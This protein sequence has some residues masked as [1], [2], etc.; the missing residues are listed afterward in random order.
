MDL[1]AAVHETR[2]LDDACL[3]EVARELPGA[4]AQRLAQHLVVRGLLTPYQ[5]DQLLSGQGNEL[6]LGP[7][8]LLDLLG[9]GGMGQVFK[10]LHNP[11]GRTVALKVIRA[12]R[13]SQ[14]PEAVRRFQREARAA[15]QLCHPNVIT[16]FDADSVDNRHYLAMEFVE[17]ID[18]SRL[19][20]Q[21]GPLPIAHACDFIRQ[22][23][24]GLQHA[25]ER[26]LVH[27]D[28]K[29]S[30]LLVSLPGN[31]AEVTDS[32]PTPPTS[33]EAGD[34][35]VIRRPLAAAT[36]LPPLGTLVK[37]VDMGLARRLNVT[38][39]RSVDGSMTEDGLLMGTPDYIAP[40][41]ARDSHRVDIRA[42]LYSLGCTFYYLLTGR[43]PFPEGSTVEK[44]LA[45]QMDEPPAVARLRPDLPV[46]VEM[47]VRKLMS[48]RPEDRYQT[49]AALAAAL[50]TMHPDGERAA[51]A[52][53][54]A[55]RGSAA[56]QPTQLMAA[57]EA[58]RTP[59]SGSAR[60]E[61]ASDRRTG[62]KIAVLKGH[63]GWVTGLA[64][65][66]DHRQLA[67]GGVDGT[68]RLWSLANARTHD[69]ALPRVHRGD[70][71]ALAFSPDGGL[72]ASGPTTLDGLVWL[73]DIHGEM[74]RDLAF[75]QAHQ[76]VTAL[77]FSPDGHT[78]AGGTGPLIRLW[79]IGDDRIKER[80]VLKGHVAPINALAFSADGQVLASAS[81]DGTARLWNPR[82]QF[83]G[84]DPPVVLRHGDQVQSVSFSPDG[85]TVASGGLDQKV[86][87]WDRDGTPG[88]TLAGHRGAIRCAAFRKDPGRLVVVDISG[89]VALWD[90]TAGRK[91]HEWTVP[92]ALIATTALTSDGR[93]LAA[94]TSDGDI[95]I[96]RLAEKHDGR[97][98]ETV[99]PAPAEEPGLPALAAVVPEA[100]P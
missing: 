87:L 12:E 16:I 58:P 6:N 95:F 82:R 7:Y 2:L 53:T 61:E 47:V 89:R 8:R 59:P 4:D 79:D 90:W 44:L 91:V 39:G 60:S 49:P 51:P 23:A 25:H 77:A 71:C 85:Q 20:R 13:L 54:S 24:L 75:V 21:H 32:E 5:A 37:I 62:Q 17:G 43:P 68:I 72:V 56:L 19:V 63:R 99:C 73:W 83:F 18:L 78:L 35:T 28:I 74:P 88:Q 69:V 38:A 86:R 29:P 11:L 80:A 67:S 57:A 92:G 96:F 41:Q 31:S 64:F 65:A 40:E 30:N 81:Q 70:V 3:E 100:A 1:L 34:A 26:G 10:A 45:H 98:P 46:T 94:A 52:L 97:R 66:S 76:S 14:N 33:T 48:K 27:R 55:P 84:K 22:A 15:A 42:D 9:E 93:H 36:L 50:A